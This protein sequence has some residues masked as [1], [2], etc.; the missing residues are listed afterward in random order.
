MQQAMLIMLCV[1]VCVCAWAD[2]SLR[3]VKIMAL[4]F[5]NICS[6][7]RKS[8]CQ[9]SPVWA[10]PVQQP[11]RCSQK[12]AAVIRS[13]RAGADLRLPNT[14]RLN[15]S[16]DFLSGCDKYSIYSPRSLVKGVICSLYAFS[17]TLERSYKNQGVSNRSLL[18]LFFIFFLFFFQG[19]DI[20]YIQ[21]NAIS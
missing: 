15:F 6:S 20:C 16:A 14:Q 11:A 8:W 13:P 5:D 19:L 10:P 17:E 2:F 1:C 4:S 12:R 3:G 9:S 7:I 18:H 21:I